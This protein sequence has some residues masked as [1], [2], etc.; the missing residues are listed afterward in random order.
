MNLSCFIWG[1]HQKWNRQEYVLEIILPV[2]CLCHSWVA[3]FLDDQ[4]KL[5]RNCSAMHMWKLICSLLIFSPLY[6]PVWYNVS[7][8]SIF[9][10]QLD[11]LSYSVW[12]KTSDRFF[13][14]PSSSFRASPLCLKDFEK[15][16]QLWFYLEDMTAFY[17]CC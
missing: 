5:A 10:L 8:W 6:S 15:W 14:F 13:F 1:A 2:S 9:K 17:W 7:S 3:S 4:Q 16:W 12:K 11:I